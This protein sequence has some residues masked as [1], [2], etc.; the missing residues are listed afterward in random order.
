MLQGLFTG[1][2]HSARGPASVVSDD[3]QG[4]LV[5]FCR[6]TQEPAVA[7]ANTGKSRERF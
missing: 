4:D 3:E 5:L 6:P 1:R 7:T 2:G